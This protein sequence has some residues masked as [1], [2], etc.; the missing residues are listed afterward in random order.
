MMP[1]IFTRALSQNCQP[2]ETLILREAI[3]GEKRAVSQVNWLP[4][5]PFAVER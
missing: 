2:N 5:K 4:V 1:M 3:G